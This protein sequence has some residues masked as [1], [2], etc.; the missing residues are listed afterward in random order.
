LLGHG[1]PERLVVKAFLSETINKVDGVRFKSLVI[2]GLY[3]DPVLA[4]EII[5]A[6]TAGW[7]LSRE[8]VGL[9]GREWG[10][11]SYNGGPSAASSLG[12]RLEMGQLVGSNIQNSLQM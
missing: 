5:V 10:V 11:L 1:C 3:G 2:G 7:Q 12:G 8:M 9:T 6:S 4:E